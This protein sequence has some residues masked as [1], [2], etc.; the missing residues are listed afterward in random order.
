MMTDAP[1][2]RS[3]RLTTMWRVAW[4]VLTT[5]VVQ[6][7]VCGLA[8]LPVMLIWTSLIEWQAPG[9]VV[10]LLTFSFMIAPS[11]VLFALVLLGLSPLATKLTGWR[12]PARA[13]MRIA[14]LDWPLLDWVRYM[15]AIHIV[16]FFAGSLF[17]GSPLW[18][19][20]LRCNGARLGR[21]VY[22]NSLAVSD[23][24]QLAF[25]DDVVIGAD[26][27]ISGHTVESGLVK[28]APVRLGDRV[29]IGLGTVVNI[30]VEAGDDCQIGA[31]SLVPKHSRLEGGAVYV[32]IPVARLKTPASPHLTS[33]TGQATSRPSL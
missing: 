9:P 1:A 31:L 28:T 21:R 29:T 4:T 30:D 20:Y 23:H 11:Y 25:G 19:A 22:I 6:G 7:T 27:H 12:T 32:G 8:V 5:C 24:S 33:S 17:R 10:R 3:R 26:V 16:R 18:T 13:E 2:G 14:D 15:V